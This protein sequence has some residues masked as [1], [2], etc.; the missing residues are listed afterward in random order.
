MVVASDV[1]GA[2]IAVVLS[3]GFHVIDFLDAP[4]KR[5]VTNHKCLISRD[6]SSIA[7]RVEG[8]KEL[9]KLGFLRSNFLQ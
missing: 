3:N 8:H 1:K 6:F 2:E 7:L 9:R 5:S 4:M